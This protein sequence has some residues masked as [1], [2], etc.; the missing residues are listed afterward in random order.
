MS[1]TC[2]SVRLIQSALLLESILELSTVPSRIDKRSDSRDRG[3]IRSAISPA[4]Q[5][6]VRPFRNGKALKNVRIGLARESAYY[7][8]DA[9][10]LQNRS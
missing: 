10:R 3:R 1:K 2:G 9:T 6:R 5:V 4:G 8:S 7:V